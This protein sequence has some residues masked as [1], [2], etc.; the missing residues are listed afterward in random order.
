M[1]ELA[2]KALSLSYLPA[3]ED[4]EAVIASRLP[5]P[6]E[7]GEI[8]PEY[9]P[10]TLPG[11]LINRIGEFKIGGDVVKTTTAM[12]MGTELLTETGYWEPGRGWNTSRNEPIAG[13]YQAY[14]LDLQGVS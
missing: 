10:D 11:Y 5:E 12:A 3:T 8:N 6:D 7:N 1:V 9:I 14:A 2:G 13:E 4:D